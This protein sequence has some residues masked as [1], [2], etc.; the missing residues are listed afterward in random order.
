MDGQEMVTKDFAEEGVA[1]L[2]ERL[3]LLY[4]AF[5]STMIEEIGEEEAERLTK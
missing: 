5:V 1:I 3:A 2:T 4:Y